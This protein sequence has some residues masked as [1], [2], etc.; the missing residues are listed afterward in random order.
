M[1]KLFLA[2]AF[3]LSIGAFAQDVIRTDSELTNNV[4]RCRLALYNVGFIQS[5]NCYYQEPGQYL[6]ELCPPF[7]NEFLT[8]DWDKLIRDYWCKHGEFPEG[9]RVM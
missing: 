3:M 4:S 9:V 6:L 8:A 1:K 7:Y 2:C 5:V